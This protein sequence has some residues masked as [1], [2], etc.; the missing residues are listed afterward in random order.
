METSLIEGSSPLLPLVAKKDSERIVI[1]SKRRG[2]KDNKTESVLK[3][4]SSPQL[5]IETNKESE[6][7]VIISGL[8]AGD[9]RMIGERDKTERVYGGGRLK[10]MKYDLFTFR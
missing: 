6:R 2:E 5:P 4:L 9:K 8:K 10:K 7:S 3:G 1:I